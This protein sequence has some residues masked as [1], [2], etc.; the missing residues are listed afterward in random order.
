M[1]WEIDAP[2]LTEVLRQVSDGYPSVPL[3][4]TENGAAFDDKVDADGS[5]NDFDRRAYFDAHLGA[6]LDAIAAGVPLHGYFAWSLMDN[7]E[8]AWGYTRRFG[9]VYVDYL[10]QT[11]TPKASAL[12]YSDVIRRHGL[13]DATPPGVSS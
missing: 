1:D 12:W 11:R 3:Y 7:Y 2:G 10:N 9:L 8:W 5:V 13:L 6:C 4:V